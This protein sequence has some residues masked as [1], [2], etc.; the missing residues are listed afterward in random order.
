MPSSVTAPSLSASRTSE[1]SPVPK[2]TA[3]SST[4]SPVE[5]A[6]PA[7]TPPSSDSGRSPMREWV[8]A[9]APSAPSAAT[10]P[11]Q[12]TTTRSPAKTGRRMAALRSAAEDALFNQQYEISSVLARRLVQA[13]G[14]WETLD[15]PT[16]AFVARTLRRSNREDE[17]LD[18]IHLGEEKGGADA[19]PFWDEVR[20]ELKLPIPAP[21]PAP[22][23]KNDES[24]GPGTEKPAPG[25]EKP[26]PG[27]ETPAPATEKPAPTEAPPTT[28]KT[29][30]AP[31]RPQ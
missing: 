28:E 25:T 7:S 26:A 3:S 18:A 16:L 15:Q 4:P 19:Q 30:E 27:A 21:P 6:R 29:P 8:H 31:A 23:G 2:T 13:A 11:S 24:P 9:L 14:G 17:A 5:I 22:M 10:P 12:A 20:T 1:P